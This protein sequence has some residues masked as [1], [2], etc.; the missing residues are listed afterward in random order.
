MRPVPLRGRRA[1]RSQ[2]SPP[3]GKKGGGRQPLAAWLLL[4]P[5]LALYL[6][7]VGIP[8][9]GVILISFLQW[10]LVSPPKWVGTSNFQA[11]AHD[12]QLASSL[13]NSFLFDIMTTTLHIV[14]GM[15]LA[16]GVTS[17]RSRVVRYSARTAIV[18]PFLMSAGVVALMWS[19]VL[20]GETGP[21]NYYLH[22][23]GITG[24]NWLG[25]STWAMPGLVIIDVWATI[26]F[27]FII[28][29]V[30]LQSIPADLHES[31]SIDGAGAMG[32]FRFI[33]LPMLS[34]A[35]LVAS[36]TA[37]I[38]AFEIFTWPLIDTSGRRGRPPRPSCSTSTGRPSRTTASAIAPSCPWSTS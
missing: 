4:S 17:I 16:L 21:L 3:P 5:A 28:F 36:V 10:D 31:A 25:S 32:R 1:G 13:L 6:A 2:L 35:T 7:F 26:G 38:G 9:I 19:Y 20:N 11:L 18:A 27:T 30:G 23:L 34:P 8:L 24:P 29:L 33:T 12:P 15:A 37:F 22:D 14:I